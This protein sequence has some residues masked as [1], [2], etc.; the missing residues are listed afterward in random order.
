MLDL[1]S[2]T[3]VLKLKEKIKRF[4]LKEMGRKRQKMLI[5]RFGFKEEISLNHAFLASQLCSSTF[6]FL[7]IVLSGGTTG[8]VQPCDGALHQHVRR[9]YGMLEANSHIQ[10][11][12]AGDPLP[13]SKDEKRRAA[14]NCSA[15]NV[16]G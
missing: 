7:R 3:K 9:V 4:H 10:K 2:L 5:Y 13:Q 12:M 11:M 1:T 8:A 14:K 6:K 15:R 16:Y